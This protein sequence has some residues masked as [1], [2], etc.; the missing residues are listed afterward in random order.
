M[1]MLREYEKDSS[2]MRNG[3]KA[4]IHSLYKS[5]SQLI[6]VSICKLR[7]PWDSHFF[8]IFI[9]LLLWPVRGRVCASKDLFRTSGRLHHLHSPLLAIQMQSS[10]NYRSDTDCHHH[11]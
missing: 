9:C 8:L 7:I 1:M 11:E 2:I 3:M 5:Q 4:L 6:S 10:V